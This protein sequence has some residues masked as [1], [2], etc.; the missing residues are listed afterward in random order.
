M[1]TPAEE[2]GLRAAAD[3]F[4]LK[5]VDV[6]RSESKL[7]EEFCWLGSVGNEFAVIAVPPVRIHGQLVMGSIGLLGSAARAMR[8]REATGAQG[9]I[10]LGMAFG[11]DRTYQA[12]GDVLVS[13]SIIPYN[14]RLI[15]ASEDWPSGYVTDYS[16]VNREPARLALVDLFRR[17]KNRREKVNSSQAFRIHVGAILSGAARIQSGAFRDELVAGVPVGD[18]PIVGGEMEG[19]GLL[20]ASV[21]FDDPIWC[22]V[23]GVSDFADEKRDREIDD[24]RTTACRN[25]AD[26]VL[27]SL[28]NDKA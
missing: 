28:L 17:E 2:G 3:G 22:V 23:K 4:G 15:K 16:Q 5:V 13:T 8:L 20:A 6:K 26:L 7:C 27:S 11:V 18:D 25:A 21:A 1:A 24:G 10:Q 9:I 19:V 12:I 14:N